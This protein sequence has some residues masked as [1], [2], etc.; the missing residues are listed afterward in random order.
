[1]TKVSVSIGNV[2]VTVES[3][4]DELIMVKEAALEALRATFE[5]GDEFMTNGCDNPNC[6]NFHPEDD[7]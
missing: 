4:D 3:D 6:P 5:M 2:G 7:E 1:M